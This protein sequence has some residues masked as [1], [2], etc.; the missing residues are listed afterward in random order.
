T[1]LSGKAHNGRYPL[2]IAPAFLITPSTPETMPC[3]ISI[4]RFT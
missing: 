4:T 3:T 2:S 1:C